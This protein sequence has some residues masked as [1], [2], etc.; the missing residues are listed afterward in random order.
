MT[1]T[2]LDTEHV[3]LGYLEAEREQRD[4]S[5]VDPLPAVLHSRAS[6]AGGCSRAI[7]FAVAKVP[8]TELPTLD[9]LVNFR[10]GDAV[11]DLVQAAVLRANPDAQKEV[12]VVIDDYMT[13]HVDVLTPDEVIEIKSQSEFGF[14][15]ATKGRLQ[16]V[17]GKER[18]VRGEPEGPKFEH[19]L[20]AGIYAHAT[21]RK[22]MRIVYVRKTAT[23]GEPTV[24]EWT[25]ALDD[26]IEDV[27]Y[28]LMRHAGIVISVRSGAL[29]NRSLVGEDA[30]DPDAIKPHW[31]CTYCSHLS[32][33]RRLGPGT[34][35]IPA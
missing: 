13:G 34:V 33:C 8:P 32:L 25:V 3:L 2:I 19:V 18:R 15:A 6:S 12:P 17:E 22:R 9:S 16:Y 29:P 4:G 30:P 21:G 14:E 28:E 24:A 20:Q 35:A 5:Y 1:P 11:H 10:V 26:V 27:T 23:K 7:G 31:R